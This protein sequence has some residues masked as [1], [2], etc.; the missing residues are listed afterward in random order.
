MKHAPSGARVSVVVA[1]VVAL[2]SGACAK[3]EAAAAPRRE[4][5]PAKRYRFA[6]MPKALNLPV[7]TYAQVGAER[8]AKQLGNVEVIWRGARG[9][10]SAQ[11]EGD[12]RVVHHAGR[13]RHRDL[14]H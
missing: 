12:P 14:V 2:A 7:F 10:R 6:V 13:R 3:T 8:A 5:A 9:R 11:A 1:A 4:R